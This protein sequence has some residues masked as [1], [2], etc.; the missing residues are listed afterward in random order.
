LLEAP[1]ASGL[2]FIEPAVEAEPVT[3]VVPQMRAPQAPVFTPVP[4]PPEEPEPAVA[5]PEPVVT[6]AMAELYA[7]QGHLSAALDVY[8]ELAMRDPS[9][10]RFADRIVELEMFVGGG[11]VSAVQTF[12]TVEPAAPDLPYLELAPEEIG[13]TYVEEVAPPTAPSLDAMELTEGPSGEV[14]ARGWHARETGG[15]PVGSWLSQVFAESLP[16]PAP[17]P[18]AEVEL[19]APAPLAESPISD[20]A[21]RGAPTRPA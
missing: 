19:P 1:R 6:E 18:V 8:R 5:E 13:E 16:T 15:T 3:A 2:T 12:E 14:P 10:P 11:E 21:P 7:S 17:A 9:D 4:L 20:V